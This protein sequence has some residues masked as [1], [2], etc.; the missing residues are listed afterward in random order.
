MFEI[1]FEKFNNFYEKIFLNYGLFVAKYYK[2]TIVISF[3]INILLSFGLFKLNLITD[4]DELFS[5]TDSKAKSDEGLLKQI[6]ISNTDYYEKKFFLHQLLDFGTWG[7]INIHVKNEIVDKNIINETYFDEIRHIHDQ[8]VNNVTTNSSLKLNDTCARRLNKCVIDGDLLLNKDFFEWLQMKAKELENGEIKL[9]EPTDMLNSP[10]AYQVI[11]EF[12]DLKFVLGKNFD[13][14]LNVNTTKTKNHGYPAYATL[15]KLRYSLKSN[16]ANMDPSV[17]EWEMAFVDFMKNVKLKYLTF[18][19]SGSHSIESEML[20]NVN[21]DVHLVAT[22]FI[23]IT[24]FATILM[25]FKTN[26]ITSPGFILPSAGIL[27]AAFACTSSIGFM[28]LINYSACNLVFV[29]PFLVLGM[30]NSF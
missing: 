2:Y 24:V 1:L 5:V 10:Y 11:P 29:I 6:F 18:T 12:V 7:E 8:I 13:Y 25:S 16:Y 4:S 3:L 19:F 28:S 26:L 30:L 21:F 14:I 15:F 17:K 22:T 9:N 23:L 20:N 27:S